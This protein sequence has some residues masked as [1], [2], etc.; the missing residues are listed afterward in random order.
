MAN[1]EDANGTQEKG[2]GWQGK[3]IVSYVPEDD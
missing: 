3:D 1:D 2:H